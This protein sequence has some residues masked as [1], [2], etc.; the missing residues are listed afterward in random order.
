MKE[1]VIGLLT[2]ATNHCYNYLESKGQILEDAID[3]YFNDA[4]ELTEDEWKRAALFFA[5]FI[6]ALSPTQHEVINE[7][8]ELSI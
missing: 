2:R 1:D 4:D 7:L 3:E 5:G 6:S 8:M